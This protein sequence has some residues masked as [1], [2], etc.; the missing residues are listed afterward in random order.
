MR[1]T[2]ELRDELQA[3]LLEMAALLPGGPAI[4]DDLTFAAA[5]TLILLPEICVLLDDP[6]TWHWR[7]VKTAFG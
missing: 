5:V 4:A 7:T 3:R 1:T 6:R 2:V